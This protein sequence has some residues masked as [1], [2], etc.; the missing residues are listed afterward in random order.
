MSAGEFDI[1]CRSWVYCRG[2][3]IQ[4]DCRLSIYQVLFVE[5]IRLWIGN[6]FAEDLKIVKLVIQS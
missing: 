5:C 3:V 6:F 1:F 2:V 4:S